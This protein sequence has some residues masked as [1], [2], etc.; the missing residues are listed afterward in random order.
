MT[1]KEIDPR[2]AAWIVEL[3]KIHAAGL[4][5]DADWRLV[6][7]S[8]YW[9]GFLDETDDDK[10]GVG[11]HIAECLMSD[12]WLDRMTE[13]SQVRLFLDIGPYFL[14]ELKRQGIDIYE[15]TIEPL[16]RFIDDL[17]PK[18]LPY[19]FASHFDYIEPGAPDELEPYR[20]DVIASRINDENGDLIGCWVGSDMH[21]APN[22]VSLLARG[23]ADM[24][25]RMARLVDPASRQAAILFCDIVG[26]TDLSRQLPSAAYFKLIRRLWTGIDRGVA[27]S[28]GVIGKH[29][30]DGA[31]AFFLVDD[32]GS[33]SAAAAAAIKTAREVHEFSASIFAEALDSPC[34]MRVGLHWGGS[35][36]MGQL[37]PGGRLDVTALGDEVNECFRIQEV[38]S[39]DQTL[40]SKQIVEQLSADEAAALGLDP[41]KLSYTTVAEFPGA[42]EKAARDAGTIPVTDI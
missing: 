26:S 25:E 29:A 7:A 1:S 9:K 6:W 4:V 20:V 11:R 27:R 15:I 17:E 30:G 8:D 33:P 18:E 40:A 31:S 16:R 13:E 38:A 3:E 41:E 36:F 35:L 14:E 39:T 2:L 19:V 34:I 32:L 5:I 21:V 42:S 23:D 37:I 22:L 28:R 10:V 24:Y 12:L